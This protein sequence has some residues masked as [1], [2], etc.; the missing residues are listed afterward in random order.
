MEGEKER[1]GFR[2]KRK[3][4]KIKKREKKSWEKERVIR[5]GER[6]MEREKERNKE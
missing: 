6:H 5:K 2:L 3:R 4:L 1:K